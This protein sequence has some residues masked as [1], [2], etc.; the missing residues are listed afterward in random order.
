[1]SISLTNERT[2]A[3]R[4]HHEHELHMHG[5]SLLVVQVEASNFGAWF[6]SLGGAEG[7]FPFSYRALAHGSEIMFGGLVGILRL[8][9]I[10]GQS[11]G[12]SQREIPFIVR[13]HALSVFVTP[14]RGR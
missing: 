3:G 10:A 9:L 2:E 12:T 1:M 8:D 14:L 6:K 11:L 7:E 13:P 5:C 4:I